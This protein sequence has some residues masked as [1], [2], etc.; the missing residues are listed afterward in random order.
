MTAQ[1]QISLQHDVDAVV[2]AY[3]APPEAPMDM[4]QQR[5]ERPRGQGLLWGLWA[6]LTGRATD[7]RRAGHHGH[8]TRA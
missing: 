5:L 6:R 8:A 7:N 2:S 1:T 3:W 4:P